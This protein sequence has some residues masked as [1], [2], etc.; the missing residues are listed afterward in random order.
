MKEEH[1]R[2]LGPVEAVEI[3]QHVGETFRI[4]GSEPPRY[5]ETR[6]RQYVNSEHQNE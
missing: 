1:R 5:S 2:T 6:L 4:N 3:L